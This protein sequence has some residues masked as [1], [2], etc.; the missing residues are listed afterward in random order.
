[1]REFVLYAAA[2]DWIEAF[3][4]SLIVRHGHHEIQVIAETDPRWLVY[5]E[6]VS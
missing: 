1:M 3:H 2:A 6:F 5:K 4:D